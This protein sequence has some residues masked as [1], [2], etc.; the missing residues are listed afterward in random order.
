VRRKPAIFWER[1]VKFINTGKLHSILMNMDVRFSAAQ[2]V[3]IAVPDQPIPIQHY[4]RQPQRLIQALINP[5]QVEDLGHNQFR[6]MMRPIHFMALTLQPTVDLEIR[7]DPSGVIRLESKACEVRGVD[8]INER[9]RLNLIGRLAPNV[10]GSKTYLF[11]RADLSVQVMVPPPISFTPQSILE[12]TGNG[13][14]HSILLT[15]K[16]RLAHHLISDYCNWVAAQQYSETS[17]DS[18][19]LL[20]SNQSAV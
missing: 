20:P 3:E 14:L 13:L 11:G 19:S 7:I 16:Q 10:V 17:S 15:I 1:I 4:L 9:F 8:Y 6:F 2:S 12:T 5:T 18:S